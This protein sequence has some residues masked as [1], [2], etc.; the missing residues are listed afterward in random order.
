LAAA[1]SSIGTTAGACRIGL[2][3]G[4][5]L[6]VERIAAQIGAAITGACRD[7]RCKGKGPDD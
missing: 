6:R 3:R 7:L 5:W 1:R 4:L 2:A